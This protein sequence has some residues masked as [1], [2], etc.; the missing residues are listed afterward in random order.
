[1]ID[2]LPPV[3]RD[4][5]EF[6]VIAGTEQ[7]AFESA[8]ATARNILDNQFIESADELGVSR[9]ERILGITP[10]GTATLD[11]RKFVILATIESQ[12]PY[13]IYHAPAGISAGFLVRPKRI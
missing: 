9:W 3:L 8:W 10:R 2:Y 4:V 6:R 12:L 5:R 7:I 13:T 11:D 1:M